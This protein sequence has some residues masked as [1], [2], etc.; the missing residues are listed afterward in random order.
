MQLLYNKNMRVRD[1]TKCHTCRPCSLEGKGMPRWVV[2]ETTRI[3]SSTEHKETV[4]V[5]TEQQK[6]D[7]TREERQNERARVQ[8]NVLKLINDW[9]GDKE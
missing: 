2:R 8:A 7:P 6:E 4:T 5:K 9:R 1:P 3:K